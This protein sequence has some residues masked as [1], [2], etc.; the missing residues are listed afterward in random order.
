[1]TYDELARSLAAGGAVLGAAELHGC[2]SGALCAQAA[3]GPG[4]W[5]AE[6]LPEHQDAAQVASLQARLHDV[7]DR[8][9]AELAGGDM[10][11]RPLLPPDEA[12]LEERVAA[13]AAWCNGFL[14]G[15]GAGG[16]QGQPGG[17]VDEVLRDLGEIGRAACDDDDAGEEAERDYVELVE[18]VR[19]AVQLVF[20]E[21]APQ[22][23]TTGPPPR[24]AKKQEDR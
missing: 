10:A 13:L 22:R 21:L 1:M 17:D 3:V 11:F 18:F 8:T 2:V 6:A 4:E 23:G 15:I 19:A 24:A 7:I 9:R 14:Y 5:A 20:E 12:V 16:L